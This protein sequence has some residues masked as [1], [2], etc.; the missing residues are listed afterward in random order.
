MEVDQLLVN[1]TWW[2]SLGLHQVAG[3]V[4]LYT[5]NRP[6]TCLAFYDY[7]S[8]IPFL[9]TFSRIVW[10]TLILQSTILDYGWDF[11]VLCGPPAWRCARCNTCPYKPRTCPIKKGLFLSITRNFTTTKIV[12][13]WLF[14]T[15]GT[16]SIPRSGDIYLAAHISPPLYVCRI[17]VAPSVLYT[18]QLWWIS[19]A[20]AHPFHCSHSNLLL[21]P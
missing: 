15:I 14:A 4:G 21:W 7:V 3:P 20:K 1:F 11:S 6:S 8:K 17:G 2:G 10:R 13:C 12:N 16:S 18:M 9:L 5:T 19:A